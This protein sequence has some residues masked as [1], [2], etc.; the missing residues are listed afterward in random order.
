[1][2]LLTRGALVNV[3]SAG[4]MTPLHL[5]AEYG[6]KEIVALLLAHGAD[7]NARNSDGQTPPQ[8]MQASSLDPAIK[9]SIALLFQ[10]K[11]KAQATIP[12]QVQAVSP[13]LV[14]APAP[15]VASDHPTMPTCW[16]VSGIVRGIRQA[17]PGI[18]GLVLFRAVKRY[19]ELLGCR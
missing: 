6:H 12:A 4:G 16:D 1:M 10:S 15:S 11:P 19:Q 18:D 14:Q 2:V 5:A 7:V 9:A 17:N 8:E 3:Q 13:A